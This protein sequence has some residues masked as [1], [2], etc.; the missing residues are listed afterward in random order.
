MSLQFN[1]AWNGPAITS[2]MTS[3]GVR[4]L[5]Q[6]AAYLQAKAVPRT[7]KDTGELRRSLVIHPAH[8]GQLFS[9]VVSNLPYA[10]RQHEELG[11]RHKHGEAKYL[12][13][14]LYDHA[15]QLQAIIANN[16]N[17]G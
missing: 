2:E 16:L 9:A 3:R 5:N 15:A 7:P 13:R 17:R 12:E 1:I 6:A 4:G 14:P 10:V 11:Y 8:A